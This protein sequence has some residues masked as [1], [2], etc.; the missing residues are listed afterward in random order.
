MISEKDRWPELTQVFESLLCPPL[1]KPLS[2]YGSLRNSLNTLANAL[3]PSEKDG[4]NGGRKISRNKSKLITLHWQQLELSHHDDSR[5]SIRISPNDKTQLWNA[6]LLQGVFGEPKAVVAI[7]TDPEKR[8]EY[9]EWAR[10]LFLDRQSVVG[11][12]LLRQELFGFLERLSLA[13]L[14]NERLP[15]PFADVLPQMGMGPHKG[16][17]LKTLAAQT[18]TLSMGDSMMT[19]YLN[20]DLEEAYKVA[21]AVNTDNPLL[22]KY[23]N[24]IQTEFKEVQGFDD[25]LDLLR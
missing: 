22:L 15:N 25:L 17:L 6:I 14:R 13:D 12:G 5:T 7:L 16:N 1:S 9:A 18:A 21:S 19:H 20:G 11:L 24:R 10:T 3:C 4:D 2:R 23:R 8:N